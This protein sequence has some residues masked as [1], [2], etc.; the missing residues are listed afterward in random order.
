MY[1]PRL[2]ILLVTLLVVV[3]RPLAQRQANNWHF[4]DGL[5][6]D[7]TDG[8]PQAGGESSMITFEGCVSISDA[9]G[10]L[11]FY[12]NGGG[13]PA[14]SGQ[15]PGMIWNRNHEVMYDMQGAEGG[16][17]SASQ[18]SLVLPVPGQEDQ[19]YLFTMEEFEFDVGG[20]F[21]DQPQGRGL[22]YFIVD[23]SLNGGLGGVTVA[24]QRVYV[25]AYEGLAAVPMTGPGQEGF[26]VLTHSDE[27]LLV[28]VPVTAAGVGEPLTYPIE[29]VAGLVDQIK[30]NPAGNLLFCNRNLIAFDP[31]TGLPDLSAAPVFIPQ[32]N[33][34]TVAFTPDNRYLYTTTDG[35]D[36]GRRLVRYD[37]TAAEIPASASP[38]FIFDA[39][40]STF[41]MQM[42][43]NGNLYFLEEEFASGTSGLSE[44]AC[45]ANQQPIL[46]RFVLDFS[47]TDILTGLPNF[48]AYLFESLASAEDT[49]VVD[50]V[51]VQT[52]P[53]DPVSLRPLNTGTEYLW[54]NGKTADTLLAIAA[55]TYAVTISGGC[56]PAVETFV[57]ENTT[58]PS[59]ELTFLSDTSLLCAD[60]DTLVLSYLDAGEPDTAT[61]FTLGI[62]ENIF[63]TDTLRLP[64][65]A[66]GQTVVLSRTYACGVVRD[67]FTYLDTPFSASLTI[68]N[69]GDNC[70][71]ERV[72]FSVIST[73]VEAIIWEDGSEGPVQTV[74][75]INSS[76]TYRATVVGL[77][78]DTL[79]LEPTFDYTG[80][81]LDCDAAIPDLITPN[82]DGT[83]DVF[84]V[85]T[86]C[87]LENYQLLVYNRWG[88]TVFESQDPARGW[89]GDKD[90]EAQ[91]MDV[92]IYRLSFQYPN[93]PNVIRRDGQFSLVR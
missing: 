40:G 18:S 72:E 8:T 45:P 58:I 33:P 44:I 60:R 34:G 39:P 84:R 57:V 91:P 74:S 41:Q 92:Y 70:P 27:V 89:T 16:G 30:T 90:G 78:G 68:S 46:N 73:G 15:N 82:N 23:M 66:G 61:W 87:P 28:V 64:V 17:F 37:L 62:D 38:L 54:S 21:P 56:Q 7:F 85:F 42:A 53:G 43:P 47:A 77:C 83:N 76:Q 67:T 71:G 1:D 88:Q 31:A 49:I 4:S 25:P 24:D 6:V 19:F 75:E 10:N 29:G 22:S 51:I 50:P 11:L 69:E 35:G 86:N 5:V 93:D 2:F 48:P 20:G 59:L 9:D 3:A 79:T 80:C 32:S 65:V 13:R 52:C 81:P 26:W 14:N 12:S 63:L 55:G 36:L